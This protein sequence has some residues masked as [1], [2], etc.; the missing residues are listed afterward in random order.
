MR[1]DDVHQGVVG[2]EGGRPRRRKDK[3]ATVQWADGWVWEELDAV[4]AD[5]VEA[6]GQEFS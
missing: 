1:L 6:V 4:K 5:G 3:R 2:G